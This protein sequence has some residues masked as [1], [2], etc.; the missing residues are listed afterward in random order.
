[1][2]GKFHHEQLYRGDALGPLATTNIVLCGAGALGSNL[3]DNLARHGAR[4]LRVVDDDRVEEHNVSTQLYGEDEVGL[5][6]VDAL[7]D[8]LFRSTGIEIETVRKRLDDANAR[9]LLR[10]A[11]LVID[12]FDNRPA[13]LAVQTAV[14]S[15]EV[16]CLHVGLNADYAEVIWDDRYTVPPDAAVGDACDYPLARNAVLLA[17]VVATEAV[18]RHLAGEVRQDHCLTLG[19]LRISRLEQDSP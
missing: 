4:S 14:R 1:M 11:G 18:L 13:R 17:T 16:G 10:G 12:A 9:K 7:Q 15:A 5:W 3:A 2:P 6:K 8:R 19:D